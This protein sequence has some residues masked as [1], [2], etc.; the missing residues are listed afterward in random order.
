MA[1][2]VLTIGCVGKTYAD[3]VFVTSTISTNILWITNMTVLGT[4]T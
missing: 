4:S 2:I 3:A 1:R